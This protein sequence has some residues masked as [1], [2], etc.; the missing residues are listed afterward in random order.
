MGFLKRFFNAKED[1]VVTK[2]I[3]ETGNG[4]FN[5]NGQLYKSDV[6]RSCIRPKS[7]AIGKLTA[8]HIRE[9]KGNLKVNPDLYMRFLLE[10]PNPF[11]TGQIFQEKMTTMLQLNNNA[12]ALIVRDNNGL[13]YQ[14]YPITV[15]G[16]QAKYK[17][18]GELYLRFN[19]RNGKIMNVDYTDVIHLRQ[20]FNEDDLFGESPLETISPLMNVVKTMDQGLINAI[21][22][23]N[24]IRWLMK[25]K[26]TIRPEDIELQIKQFTERYLNVE[27]EYSGVVGSDSKYDLEHVKTDGSV[28]VANAGQTRETMTRIYNFFNTNEKI[29]Q[30]KWDENDWN[31]Y[32]EAEIEPLAKQ[33]SGEYTRKLFSRKQRSL[34]NSIMFDAA[35]L[36][37]ASM[38]TKLALVQLVDRGAMTPN[39][40]RLVL[41]LSPIEGGEKP[42]RRLDTAVVEGGENDG[43]KDQGD[44]NSEFG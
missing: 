5:F 31:S 22:N 30:S 8:K 17:E 44:N 25:F 21:K 34:G 1:R 7:K 19:L 13:P 10:E 24:I 18:T 14:L 26:G 4:F 9:I 35:S 27:S 33:M 37:Y 36:A 28:F 16:V 3:T 41:N 11:M 20:D 38:S 29:V 6:I 12:F 15:Y 23:S 39:E 32:Y 40:W 43:D 42:I 2:F